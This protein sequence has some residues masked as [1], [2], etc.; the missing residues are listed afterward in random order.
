MEE[1]KAG[2]IVGGGSCNLK[3]NGP[4]SSHEKTTSK[5]T[6]KKNIRERT[7]QA[8]ETAS[9]KA[10]GWEQACCVLGTE[11]RSV[12]WSSYMVPCPAASPETLS[13]MQILRPSWS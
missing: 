12:I 1:N 3:P 5:K 2:S 6:F 8:E 9:A 7:F 10:L 11:R 4:K 13:E